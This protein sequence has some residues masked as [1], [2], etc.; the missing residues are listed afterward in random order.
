MCFEMLIADQQARGQVKVNRARYKLR[1]AQNERSASESVVKKWGQSLSNK[2]LLDAGGER[3]TTMAEN[4]GRK[5]DADTLSSAMGTLRHSEELG[6]VAAAAASAGVGGSSVEGYNTTMETVYALQRDAQ[7]RG[8]N[9]ENYIATKEMGRAVSDSIDMMD[10]NLYMADRDL[11]YYGDTKGPSALG[12][13]ATIGVA[14]AAAAAGAPDVGKTIIDAKT[15]S[16]QANYGL[17]DGGA[18]AMR[19]A[20]E[21]FKGGVGQIRD[22]FRSNKKSSSYAPTGDGSNM[23]GGISR[24]SGGS[25]SIT[26]R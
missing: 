25:S 18:A 5:L 19:S 22:A 21:N 15:A 14:A 10:N 17:G 26:F 4:L 9:S 23:S 13:L 7:D 6:R 24:F 2:K 1:D 3:F 16:L 12:T 20:G 11:G 8:A